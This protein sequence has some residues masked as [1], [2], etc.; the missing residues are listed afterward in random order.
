MFNSRYRHLDCL[1]LF[2]AQRLAVFVIAELSGDMD[3]RNAQTRMN[4]AAFGLG[5]RLA[6]HVDI[7]RNRTRKPADHRA[8]DLFGDQ[9]DRLKILRRRD[10]KSRLDNIHAQSS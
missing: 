3:I 1:G 8:V 5:Q 9:L 4:A 10:R 2:L 7:R 6:A